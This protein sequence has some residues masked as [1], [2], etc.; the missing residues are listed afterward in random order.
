M[1][2]DH[3]GGQHPR[4]LTA[5][6]K[7]AYDILGDERTRSIRATRLLKIA[8]ALGLEVPPALSAGADEVIE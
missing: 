8:N 4:G 7:F 3:Q 1:V 2:A 6:H 5:T